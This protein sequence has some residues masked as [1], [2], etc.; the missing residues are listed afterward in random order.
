MDKTSSI[1]ADCLRLPRE[2]PA[3]P[4][5]L[6]C[7]HFV[8]DVVS[9]FGP[10]FSL[11][12][13][14]NDVLAIV[15][16]YLIWPRSVVQRLQRFLANRCADYDA[17]LGC[18]DL[19][20]E[21]FMDRHGVWPGSLAAD[22]TVYFYLDEFV[23]Q[24]SKDVQSLL[25]TTRLGLDAE[26]R[27]Q[28]VKLIDNIALLARVLG[29]TS[30]EA[31][32]LGACALAKYRRDV[33]TVLTD[34]KLAQGLEAYQFLA[35]MAKVPALDISGALQPGGR[36]ETLGLIDAPLSEA[37]ISD[38]GDVLRLADRFLPPLLRDYADEA[39]LMAVFTRPAQPTRLAFADYAHIEHDA[40]YLTALLGAS[41]QKGEAGVNILI[42]GPPGTGKTELA[43]LL[44]Q[45]AHCELYE[46]ESANAQG[47]SMSGRDR[48]RSM[49]I[50]QSFLKGRRNTALLFDEVEDVFPASAGMELMAFTGVS[51]PSGSSVSGKAWVNRTLETN[52]VPTIWIS[53]NI[54]QIDAAYLRRFQYHLELKNPP[55]N[56]R[57][58][59]VSKHLE[60]L[61]VSA[62]FV[63][64]LVERPTLTPAQ[65]E[66]AVRFV[67][68]AR[69]ALDEPAEALIERQLAAS[70]RAMGIKAAPG[71]RTVVTHYDLSLLNFEMDFSLERMISA[72]QTKKSGTLCFYGMP[73]SGKT[74]LA[75][76]MAQAI[77]RPLMIRRASDLVS[78]F[79]GETEKNMAAMFDQAEQEG[80][81][82]LLDEADSFLNSRGMAE[83]NFEVSEVNEM[84]QGMERFKGIFVCTTNLIDRIDEAALRRFSFK[85]KF[86]ALNAEQ[87]ERMFIGEALGG[88]ES[89]F[90]ATQ[91]ARLKKLPLLTPGDF[92]TARRQW[93]LFDEPIDADRFLTQL[94]REHAIKPEVRQERPMGFVRH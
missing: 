4:T 21:E 73:G 50:A 78:K 10:R 20:V 64:R 54:R 13:N 61:D 80:A 66:S 52:P 1:S 25:E 48:Y 92:A 75:E 53:N 68:L 42:Y 16:P 90:S 38:L 28:P 40:R 76:H 70:D 17:W 44:A 59:I 43:R 91:R 22:N 74:A 11:R 15:A 30:A 84:L 24:N 9:Q 94:E 69:T 27:G 37:S 32:L 29:L 56:V 6:A 49:Q 67:H 88:K 72:L 35:Q 14:I 34:C 26:L 55:A 45:E 33:H 36:L 79:V 86:L 3:T 23:K 83:R 58:K 82:L 93:L 85:I 60:G 57:Q 18:A 63:A 12:S 71:A 8:L 19:S 51:E 31:W 87:R 65:I 47:G 89:L 81:V 5:D 41:A 62:E 2:H 39:E 7:A 77:G 46:V